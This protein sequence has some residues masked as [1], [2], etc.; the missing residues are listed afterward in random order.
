MSPQTHILSAGND[1]RRQQAREVHKEEF[2]VNIC[3]EVLKEMFKVY[4]AP[5]QQACHV[6]GKWGF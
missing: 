2:K 1:T 4:S 6:L 5:A 3:R